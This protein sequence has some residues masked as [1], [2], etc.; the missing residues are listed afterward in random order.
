M[1]AEGLVYG[2]GRTTR[3][4]L[5]TWWTLSPVL[6]LRWLGGQALR[7][8]DRL[9]PE[10]GVPGGWVTE[11]MRRPVVPVPDC[12]TELRVWAGDVDEQRFA[13]K[14]LRAGRPLVVAVPDADCRYTLSIRPDT[15][16]PGHRDVRKSDVRKCEGSWRR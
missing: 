9:D 4:V 11:G 14:C 13:R 5:G 1:V 3:Y 12:P 7:I 10:P 8:A 6:A 2:T 16:E 15:G